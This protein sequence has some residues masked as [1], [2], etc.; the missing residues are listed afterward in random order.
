MFDSELPIDALSMLTDFL[1]ISDA[2]TNSLVAADSKSKGDFSP[3]L[4]SGP[5]KTLARQIFELSKVCRTELLRAQGFSVMA[6][7]VANSF[8]EEHTR[9]QKEPSELVVVEPLTPP[10]FSHRLQESMHAALLKVMEERD[11]S[12]AHLAAA[13][14]L[15]VHELEQQR[16][17]NSRLEAEL[18]ASRSE[19]TTQNVDRERQQRQFQMQQNSD[20]ELM[21]LCQ[22]L[23][24]EISARTAATLEVTR[25]KE[26]HQI[27]SE[28]H[29]DEVQALQ[30]EIVRLRA[31]LDN[32]RSKAHSVS[33]ELSGLR[34]LYKNILK[35]EASPKS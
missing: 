28:Q 31:E 34:R 11:M 9:A 18:E 1:E 10:A 8:G 23:A 14:V 24:G 35:Y 7:R 29:K 33:T 32:E 13:E 25:L 17:R 20:E 12:H 19:S 22:Q 30:D 15:H 16:K 6:E 26:G 3:L 2:S 4:K 21:S 27:K 5:T